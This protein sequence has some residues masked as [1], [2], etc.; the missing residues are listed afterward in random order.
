MRRLV[1]VSLIALL[2]G[3]AAADTIVVSPTGPLSIQAA[4]DLANDGDIVELLDGIYTGD[5]NRDILFRGKAI[6]VQSQSG[7]PTACIIDCEG[8]YRDNHR[9]FTFAHYEGLDSVVGGLTI[10]GGYHGWSGGIYCPLGDPTIRDCRFIGNTGSE[11]AGLCVKGPAE[12]IGCWFESNTSTSHGGGAS[13]C[14]MYGYIATFR[15]CTF[16]NNT[17]GQY[18]GAFRC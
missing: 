4:I 5:G 10:T 3:V 11:G 9:A 1:F 15:E 13:A 16:V 2:Y 18:G 17:A 12:I 8:N 6:T 7:D 14:S